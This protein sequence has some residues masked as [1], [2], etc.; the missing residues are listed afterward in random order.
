[1]YSGIG[2]DFGGNGH[3]LDVADLGDQRHGAACAWIGLEHV[4]HVVFDGVLHVHKAAHMHGFRDALG[5]IADG[6]Q[7]LF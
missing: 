3:H 5:V 6:S 2:D 1:M 7:V 4:D